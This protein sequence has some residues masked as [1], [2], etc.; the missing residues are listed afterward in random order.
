MADS[1]IGA[2]EA[3]SRFSELIARAGKGESFTVTKSGRPLARITPIQPVERERARAAGARILARLAAVPPVSPED[4][5]RNYRA[6]KA[7]ADE[8]L[9]R[10]AEQWSKS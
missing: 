9:R 6:M 5:D 2:Y 10:K 1:V 7:D 8:S 4:A 3:K